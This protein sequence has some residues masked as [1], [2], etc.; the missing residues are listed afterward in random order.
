MPEGP[1][2][3]IMAD[4]INKVSQDR[5]YQKITRSEVA[6]PV[7][8]GLKNFTLTA[9]SRGKE[10]RLSC[11]EKD[12]DTPLVLLCRMGMSGSW[13]FCKKGEE[14]KHTHLFFH[15]GNYVLG[16]NDVRRFG[17]YQWSDMWGTKRGPDPMREFEEFVENIENQLDRK[18]FQKHLSEL[19]L[20]QE[21][22]NGIGN[23]LRAEVLYRLDINPFQ[24]L[25][26]LNKKQRQALYEMIQQVMFESYELGGGTLKDWK[27]PHS[28]DHQKDQMKFKSWLQCYRQ[29][30]MVKKVKGG[31]SFWYHPKWS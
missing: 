18:I 27:N 2:L 22:F 28:Q 17:N 30:S 21:F 8:L 31:R 19:L 10:L 13:F 14:P 26:A 5:V 15:S 20:N 7:H 1:E 23:Y 4:F 6:K 29:E 11:Q 12:S 3:R 24:G 25:T 9:E 16:Y